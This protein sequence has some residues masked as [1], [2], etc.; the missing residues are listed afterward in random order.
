MP[1]DEPGRRRASSAFLSIREIRLAAFLV[2][3][4]MTPVTRRA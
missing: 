3:V 1:A 2:L 4:N